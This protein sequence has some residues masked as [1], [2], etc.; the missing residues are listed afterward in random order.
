LIRTRAFLEVLEAL[1]WGFHNSRDG[2]CFPSYEAIAAKAEC[3]Q[4]TVYE[5]LKVLELAGV[6]TW[7]HRITRIQVRERDLFGKRA[8]RWRAIRTSNA[9]V[10]HDPQQ[11][12]EGPQDFQYLPAAS[13]DPDSPLERAL[14]QLGASIEGRLLLNGSGGQVPIQDADGSPREKL[15]C[16][17]RISNGDA[18]MNEAADVCLTVTEGPVII[19]GLGNAAVDATHTLWDRIV[20]SE[21]FP[22]GSG[23]LGGS[24]V[25]T[26]RKG[27]DHA[28]KVQRAEDDLTNALL[29]LAA[30]CRSLVDHT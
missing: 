30:A 29:M 6:L 3:C 13:V 21:K 1:L 22:L 28:N 14:R 27:V 18:Q 9:Y 19:S 23:A 16:K 24:Y 12:P 7:T 26:L 17:A 8:S 25:V 4:D 5:A 10:F 2:R 15:A 11:R 20:A